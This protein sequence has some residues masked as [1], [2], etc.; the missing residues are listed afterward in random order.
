MGAMLMAATLC[1]GAADYSKLKDAF[2]DAQNK[3]K[4]STL[5]FEAA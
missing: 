1:A 4:C 2:C 3:V 5:L